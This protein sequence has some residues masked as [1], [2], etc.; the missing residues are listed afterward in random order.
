MKP[1]ENRGNDISKVGWTS[2][3]SLPMLAINAHWMSS[4]FQQ[5]RACIEFVE[6]VSLFDALSAVI[7]ITLS[8]I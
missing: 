5:Y 8:D 3:N 1:L 2:Q 4:A 7:V 6:R